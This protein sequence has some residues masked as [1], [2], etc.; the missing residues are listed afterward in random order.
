MNQVV[1][2]F[3]DRSHPSMLD[4]REVLEPLAIFEFEGTNTTA[5]GV[6]ASL[7]RAIGHWVEQHS[8]G[9]A[10]ETKF[11]GLLGVWHIEP[12]LSNSMSSLAPFLER[13]GIMVCRRL[14]WK[15]S[16]T[17]IDF[18]EV[19]WENGRKRIESNCRERCATP[20]IA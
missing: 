18:H 10:L 7:E 17:W 9:K 2:V 8:E 5:G 3:S 19:L 16:A 13:E 11:G 15:P 1:L 12:E 20:D 14:L 6:L 4:D